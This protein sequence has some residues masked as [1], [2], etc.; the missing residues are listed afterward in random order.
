[1][2]YNF[3]SNNK[4]GSTLKWDISELGKDEVTWY[5]LRELVEKEG[6]D[7]L[8]F[9]GYMIYNTQSGK[10]IA[11][12]TSKT[13][14]VQIPN[15]YMDTLKALPKEAIDEMKEKGVKINNFSL[16][17]YMNKDTVFFD[18]VNNED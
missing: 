18:F 2:G 17:T 14:L 9:Y 13:E 3:A 11:V 15:R 5:K 10:C 8:T 16:S 12:Q 7:S 6:I 4:K 1:M